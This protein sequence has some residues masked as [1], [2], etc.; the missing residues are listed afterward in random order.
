MRYRIIIL[1]IFYLLLSSSEL[2]A[3]T[4]EVGPG[5]TYTTPAAA[6]NGAQPGDTVLIFPNIYGGGNFI[7]N[8]HGT[9]NS[10]IYFIGVDLQNVIFQGGNQA[11]QFSDVSYIRIENITIQGQT[12]NGFNIDDGGSYD[13]PT[14]HIQIHNCIFKNMNAGGNNDLLKMSGVDEF[15]ITQCT[16]MNG[17]AGGSGIDMVGCHLGIIERCSFENLGSNCIQAK[18]GTRYI[19]IKRNKFKNGGQRTLNLGGSTGLEF[20][21]PLNA[22]FEAADIDVYA[23]II[24]GSTAAIAYVGAVRINVVNNTIVNPTNWVARILQETVD[25]IRFLPCGQ[26]T[27]INNIVYYGNISTHVNVGNNT[28]P[29]TFTFSNNLWF[30]HT[31]STSSTP[32]LP[33]IET[34]PVVGQNPKFIH[35]PSEN[36][37]LQST[38]PAKDAGT[39]TI[40]SEDYDGIAGIFGLGKD[41]GAY[42]YVAPTI[43]TIEGNHHVCTSGSTQS[44]TVKAQFSSYYQW[45]VTGGILQPYQ[46]MDTTVVIN[47]SQNAPLHSM[48]ITPFDSNNITGNQFTQSITLTTN[49]TLTW[50]GNNGV[51]NDRGN[52]N[53]YTLPQSCHHLVI[54]TSPSPLTLPTMSAVTIKS[55]YCNAGINIIV[56][57]NST[58]V[59]K[60]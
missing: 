50:I 43:T 59:I 51:W 30:K 49:D 32:T 15:S 20:F 31:D 18:G 44:Y 36:Y 39:L 19:T 1:T 7:G 55:L 48:S 33:V 56:P 23:N 40:F 21:R 47:W 54:Q 37:K 3:V 28:A 9:A 35:I 2:T 27:F 25:P 38:S 14:H 60:E 4:R 26:S 57:Q 16:F 58:L 29:S 17:A 11:F 8:L 12:A 22:T 46:P 24:I 52:W 13:T 41:I 10:Y 53:K 5:K 34:N 45:N 42:E 6:A